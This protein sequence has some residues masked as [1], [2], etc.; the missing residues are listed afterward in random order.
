MSRLPPLTRDK[1]SSPEQQSG[2]DELSEL[3][4][5]AFGD[6]FIWKRKDGAMVGPF[7]ALIGAPEAG[8]DMIKLVGK[9]ATIPGLPAD[10]KETAI[11]STGAHYKALYEL[12]AHGNV[13]AQTTGLFT[14]QVEQ[15]CDG[16]KPEGLNEGC[17]VAYDI[18]K[19]LS[20]IPGPLPKDL[21]DRST[22]ALGK[23][24]TLALVHYVGMYAYTCI[25]LNAMDAPVPKDDE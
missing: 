10:A 2:H 15:I 16:K 20:S 9:L 6:K 4:G 14:E 3:A 8:V 19:H 17:S 13:A 18:A 7:P 23:D 5:K 21:W 11:L 22:K 24:G 25:I 1:L 12:Y